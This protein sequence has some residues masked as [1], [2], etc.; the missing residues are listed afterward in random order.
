MNKTQKVMGML[1]KKNGEM[2]MPY[3]AE[4]EITATAEGMLTIN[5]GNTTIIVEK[6]D[7]AKVMGENT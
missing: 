5:A 2:L 3:P 6:K 7:V 4:V 1:V